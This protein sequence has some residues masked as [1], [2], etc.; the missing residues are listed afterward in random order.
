MGDAI[1]LGKSGLVRQLIHYPARIVPAWTPEDGQVYHVKVTDCTLP[2][3]NQDPLV[4][5]RTIVTSSIHGVIKPVAEILTQ[6]HP[7]AHERAKRQEHSFIAAQQVPT[8][9]DH[10]CYHKYAFL[11]PVNEVP[12]CQS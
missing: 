6:L 10:L 3:I 12:A 4:A 11:K 2:R 9:P 7:M 8:V 5:E 1:P